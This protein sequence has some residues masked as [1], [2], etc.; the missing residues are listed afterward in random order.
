MR[1]TKMRK[2][3]RQVENRSDLAMLAVKRPLLLGVLNLLI[4]IAGVAA[5]L[6]VEV[7]ELPNV[8][9][10]IVSVTASLPGA[11]PE[12]MDAEVTSILENA[13]ARVSGV[14]E[15]R[16]SSEENNTRIRVEFNP[17]VDLDTAASD[18]REA[19]SRTQRDLPERV[20][21]VTVVKADQ[22]ARTLISLA[23]AEYTVAESTAE[24]LKEEGKAEEVAAVQLV[25][26][27]K[28]ELMWDKLDI[29]KDIAKSGRKGV[30]GERAETMMNELCN[31]KGPAAAA[32]MSR[33]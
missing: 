6:G 19:V 10:P 2:A 13:A 24:S 18:I 30:T 12:T 1:A 8:D 31:M 27:R 3:A 32:P 16:S 33:R 25:E 21:Q 9:R 29:L 23:E 14:R 11:A 5:L 22:D 17:G 4:V 15:I 20:E 26:K 28:Y 7:R